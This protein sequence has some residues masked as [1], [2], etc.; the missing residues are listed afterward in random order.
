MVS[1]LIGLRCSG[2][3]KLFVP[4]LGE[5]G[6]LLGFLL[7]DR[8]ALTVS[9]PSGQHPFLALK[10]VLGDIHGAL[11]CVISDSDGIGISI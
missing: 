10:L 2:F 9:M 8:E 3:P 5:I 1:V 4:Y 11:C 7:K 6:K